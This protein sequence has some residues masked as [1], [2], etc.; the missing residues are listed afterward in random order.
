MEQVFTIFFVMLFGAI[1]GWYARE[2]VAVNT[3]KK[4]LDQ[5][6]Q[7]AEDRMKIRLELHSGIMYAYSI[8]TDEFLGQGKTLTEIDEILVAKFPG[9]QFA[10][11][12]SNLAE[13]DLKL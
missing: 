4:V 11:K 2:Q 3:I 5:A 1:V 9:K 7:I 8:D 12:E 13:L 10:V 6:E